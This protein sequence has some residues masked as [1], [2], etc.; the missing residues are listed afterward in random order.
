MDVKHVLSNL[1]NYDMWEY[2]KYGLCNEEADVIIPLLER[3]IPMCPE[4]DKV[5]DG[6]NTFMK[7]RVCPVCGATY[8]F[9]PNFCKGCGQALRR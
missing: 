5:E 6:E 4:I 3:A 2:Q 8:N 7:L 1:K 9:T